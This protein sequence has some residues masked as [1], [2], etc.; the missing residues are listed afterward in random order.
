MRKRKKEQNE[1]TRFPTRIPTRVST[2]EELDEAIDRG[3]QT[4]RIVGKLAGQVYRTRALAHVSPA[5]LGSA[6]ASLG[7]APATGGLSL[8][9]G[10]MPTTAMS[11]VSI[12]ALIIAISIGLSLLIALFKNYEVIDYRHGSL[13]LHKKD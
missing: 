10:V 6:A 11:G 1:S 7:F 9:L 12:G 5:L 13:T 3:C 8:A 4:I 2:K